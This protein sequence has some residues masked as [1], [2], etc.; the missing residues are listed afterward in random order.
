MKNEFADREINYT[1]N[2]DA[3]ILKFDFPLLEQALTNIIHNSIEYTPPESIINISAYKSAEY[4]IITIAD[5]GKG[6]PEDSIHNLFK[7]FYRIPG[8]KAGGI[9][10]GLSIARGF[11]EAHNGSISASNR[12]SGG[13]EFIIKLPLN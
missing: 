4:V 10:L 3:L 6:F 1:A 9:G 8:T 2:E 5:N 13:A 12:K 11:I 7:K